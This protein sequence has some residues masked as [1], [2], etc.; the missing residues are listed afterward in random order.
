VSASNL[1]NGARN[2]SKT[3]SLLLIEDNIKSEEKTEIFGYHVFVIEIFP[4]FLRLKSI[5]RRSNKMEFG[6]FDE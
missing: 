3:S 4:A 5:R 1:S 6:V 2:C